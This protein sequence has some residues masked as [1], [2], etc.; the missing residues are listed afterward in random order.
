M[1]L[2]DKDGNSVKQEG[3]IVRYLIPDG[4]AQKGG[5]QVNDIILQVGNNVIFKPSDIVNLVNDNGIN[6]PLKFKI[7]R[8]GEI[9]IFSIVP[10][11]MNTLK[12]P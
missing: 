8:L 1:P 11:D 4:P 6:K 7:K 12:I 9:K 3:A 2:I 10:V 5:L